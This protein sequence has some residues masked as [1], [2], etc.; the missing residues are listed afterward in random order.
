MPQ[1]LQRKKVN[2]INNFKSQKFIKIKENQHDKLLMENIHKID[3]VPVRNKILSRSSSATAEHSS[4]QK[5]SDT[6]KE[7][8]ITSNHVDISDLQN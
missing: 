6:I 8:K 4:R 2:K 3:S 5:I 7:K 1:S